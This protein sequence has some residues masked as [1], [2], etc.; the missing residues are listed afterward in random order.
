MAEQDIIYTFSFQFNVSVDATT[1][2]DG[3]S[4]FEVN[5]L[6]ALTELG[7]TVTLIEGNS[8]LCTLSSGSF[9]ESKS[10]RFYINK[11]GNY[12]ARTAS[13]NIPLTQSYRNFGKEY[14]NQSLE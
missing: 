14:G 13:T 1:I 9:S 3:A 4:L 6:G 2:N 8:F 7:C 10:Y 11:T 12:N 5:T